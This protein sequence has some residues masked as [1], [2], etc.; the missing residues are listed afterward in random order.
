MTFG[1]TAGS[2]RLK[3]TQESN[4]ENEDYMHNMIHMDFL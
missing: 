1:E 3:T 2:L 4:L